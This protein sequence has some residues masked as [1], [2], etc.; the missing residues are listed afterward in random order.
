MAEF[1]SAG[2][3]AKMFRHAISGLLT[4]AT[5]EKMVSRFVKAMRNVAATDLTNLRGSRIVSKGALELLTGFN[6]NIDSPLETVFYATYSAAID[7]VAGTLKIDIP[8]FQPNTMLP[9][10]PG[11]THFK[12]YSAGLEIDFLKETVKLDSQQSAFLPC[13]N[14]VTANITQLHNATPNS[15]SHL[16]LLMGVQFYQEVNGQFYALQ[17]K[18]KNPLAII[19]VDKG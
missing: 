5:D 8:G 14:N 3:A 13:D 10:A 6:F 18:K 4:T 17:N 1:G 11:A 19:S 12:I 15:T 2:K 7:R 9:P 16:F